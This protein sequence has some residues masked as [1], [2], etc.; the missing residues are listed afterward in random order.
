MYDN[1]DYT[2]ISGVAGIIGALLGSAF[3]WLVIIAVGIWAWRIVF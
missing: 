3:F 1:D 2:P